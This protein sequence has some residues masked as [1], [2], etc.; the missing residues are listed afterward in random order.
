[1]EIGLENPIIGVGPQVLPYEIARYKTAGY[2]AGISEAHNVYAHVIGGSGLICFAAMLAVGWALCSWKLGD[3][4]IDP[5]Q[6]PLRRARRL[7]RML[8]LLWAVRALFTAEIL[9]NPS[10]NMAIGLV[11]GYCTLAQTAR[12]AERG[13]RNKS[14]PGTAQLPAVR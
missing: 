4:D 12:G 6:D 1:L 8:V 2:N 13:A 14:L 7:M 9:F 5:K 11:I 3:A 10:F